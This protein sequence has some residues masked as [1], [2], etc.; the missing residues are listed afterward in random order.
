MSNEM[1]RTRAQFLKGS[2]GVAALLATGGLRIGLGDARAARRSTT[3]GFL[4]WQGY[5]GTPASTF[6]VLTS[7]EQTAGISTNATYIDNNPEVITKLQASGPGTYDLCSPVHSV[8]PSMIAAG[9][10]QPIPVGRLKNW[11]SLDPLIR[12]QKYLR[13]GA[14]VYAV[15]LGYGYISFPL[16]NPEL[17]PKPPTSWDQ[18]LTSKY[19]RKFAVNDLPENLTWI[20]RTLGLGHPDPHHLKKKDLARCEAYARRLVK[21]SKTVS[22]TFGDLLQLFVT[23]EIAFSVSG[24]PD[25]I[26][27]AAAQGV[28]LKKWFPKEGGAGAYMDNFAIPVGARN[29]DAALEWIDQMISPQVNAEL[30]SVYGGGPIN[31]RSRTYLPAKLQARYPAKFATFFKQTPVYPA[32]P[33]SSSVFAN[34]SDWVEAWTSAKQG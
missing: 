23:K 29:A 28:T 32:Q 26:D 19:R 27:K 33:T 21:N 34:Y 9:L 31:G 20:A 7:W 11:Q 3:L 1:T 25:I 2:A 6:P 24:T 16:Y 18:L 8:V 22:P 17:I 4:G 10:L 14:S 13:R 30:A 15:P 12:N 5:D